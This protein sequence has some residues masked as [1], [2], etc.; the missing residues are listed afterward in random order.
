MQLFYIYEEDQKTGP[1]DLVSVIKKIRNGRL[2]PDQLVITDEL[3]VPQAASSILSL[4]E[5][6]SENEVLAEE[7]TQTKRQIQKLDV[8]QILRDAWMTFQD[9]QA[10]A[11]FA[12]LGCFLILSVSLI[13]S[14]I[15]PG[16]LAAVLC[17]MLAGMAYYVFQVFILYR[18]RGKIVDMDFL[19][20]FTT[21][22]GI[23]FLIAAACLPGI[24]IGI[25]VLLSAL[26]GEMSYLLIIPATLVYGLFIFT[27]F[28]FAEDE[29]N[30]PIQTML[31][32]SKRWF[33]S[34]NLDTIGIL[35]FIFSVNFVAILTFFIPVF[36]TLPLTALALVDIYEVYFTR[37]LPEA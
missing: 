20:Q 3:D 10:T 28:I 21:P 7:E 24:L 25:P 5:Y 2:L 22:R 1:F 33:L 13:F 15:L 26:I 30:L 9:H 29:D 32:A 16:N 37:D 31:L 4:A 19:R 6:F 23:Q 17:V 18:F 14:I 34:Q 8:S 12:G 27:P 11:V 35:L 36:V